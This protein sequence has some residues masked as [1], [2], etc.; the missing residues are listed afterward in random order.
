MSHVVLLNLSKVMYLL[1]NLDLT[2]IYRKQILEK[3]INFIFN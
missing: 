1:L 3:T 2:I